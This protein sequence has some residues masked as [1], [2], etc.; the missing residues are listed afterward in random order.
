MRYL[1]LFNEE[2]APRRKLS[3]W[4][5][6]NEPVEGPDQ[7]DIDYWE[8]VVK[9]EVPYMKIITSYD[10]FYIKMNTKEV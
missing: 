8:V 4:S 9:N 6:E 2:A 7:Q 1:K 5:D 10:T 3:A